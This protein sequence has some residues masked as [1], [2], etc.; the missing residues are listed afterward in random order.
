MAGE[1]LRFPDVKLG[2]FAINYGTC[3]DPDVAVEVAQHAEAAGL[4][5]IWSGE[6]VVLPDPRPAGF[7]IAPT[8][9]FLDTT[10]ALTLVATHTTTLNVASGV[11]ILPL[12]NPVV[13][14]KQ[15]ASLDVVSR[16]RLIVGVGAG[17]VPGEFAAAGVALAERRSR[18]DDYIR[19]MRALWTMVRPQHKGPHVCFEGVDAHPRPVRPQGPPLVVGGHAGPALVR[20]V[21]MAEGWYGFDLDPAETEQLLSDLRRVASE[22]ERPS[23]LG[24]LEITVTP[25][26]PIDHAVIER[27]EALGVDRLVMLPSLDAARAQRHSPVPRERILRNIDAIVSG[28]GS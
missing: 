2:L 8:V 21:T 7:S 26:G 20:A 27:Y 18:M 13:L 23:D 22:H 3:A 12:R 24:P 4:E 11:I 9:P 6:H 14:A 1:A 17:Y 15:L 19:A 16:G 5:S 10:V 28:G 25:R